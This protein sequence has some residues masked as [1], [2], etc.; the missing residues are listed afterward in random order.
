MALVPEDDLPSG[1]VPESDLPRKTPKQMRQEPS[2]LE[3][4]GQ[5]LKQATRFTPFVGGLRLGAKAGELYDKASYEAGGRVT[6]ITGS[7]A[8]GQ[9]TNIAMQAIPSLIAPGTLSRIA[10]RAIALKDLVKEGTLEAGRKLGLNVPPSAVGSGHVERGIESLGG[11]ADIGREMSS[12]NREA[13]QVVARKEAGIP[14]NQPITEDT[15]AEA[16]NKIAEPYR[17]ISS[18]SPQ[19]AKALEQLKSTRQEAKVFWRHY[20][21]QAN[22]K[23]L[24][25][26]KK[27]DAKAEQLEEKISKIAGELSPDLLPALRQ[28]RMQLAKN[29]D[30]EK[31]LN[32]GTGEI[33]ARKIGRLIDKRGVKGVTGDLGTIGKFA[34][35]FPDFVQPKD[36]ARDVSMVRPYLA[37]GALGG[38]GA[39]SEHYTGTPYGMALGALPFISPAARALALSKL[40]QSG[41]LQ[42]GASAGRAAASSMIP[43]S[44]LR[45]QYEDAG[46]R[47]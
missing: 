10:P 19:A 3:E 22:P 37:L 21:M 9:A 18:L 40:M 29:F 36:V 45:S 38:G 17:R 15:L 1:L 12:R 44:N 33:D 39:L 14:P 34:Q 28:A 16:R 46:S 11:K 26:A 24:A 2:A 31:A 42:P 32:V 35:A 43:L 7:P 25:E 41:A 6:D 4:T 5:F 23:S 13:I 47:P 30:I 8:L 27:L 20:D